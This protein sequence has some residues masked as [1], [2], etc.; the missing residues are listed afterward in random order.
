MKNS[1]FVLF[2]NWPK[3]CDSSAAQLIKFCLGC[4][5]KLR[6]SPFST[7]YHWKGQKSAR[8]FTENLPR[9]DSAKVCIV[10]I[11]LFYLA[12]DCDAKIELLRRRG[13]RD[14]CTIFLLLAASHGTTINMKLINDL[15][16]ILS[17]PTKLHCTTVKKEFIYIHMGIGYY[18]SLLFSRS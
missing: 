5:Q 17:V 11:Y 8:F 12:R 2:T 6:I 10:H 18:I 15:I 1:F 4:S 16:I 13:Y 7:I 3:L 14:Y 9:S